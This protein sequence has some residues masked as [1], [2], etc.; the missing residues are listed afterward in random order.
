MNFFGTLALVLAVSGNWP[1]FSRCFL[2]MATQHD[3][4]LRMIPFLDRHLV[5]PLLQF[6]E[7]K[8]VSY[9]SHLYTYNV[10]AD[11]GTALRASR[12]VASQV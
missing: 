2:I 4:T 3:L 9:R 10:V 1:L 6:L 5:F 11:Q 8:E 7:L 12:S